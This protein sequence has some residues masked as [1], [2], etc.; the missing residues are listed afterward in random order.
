VKARRATPLHVA[1]RALF[2]LHQDFP[3]W[4]D[5]TLVFGFFPSGLLY[6]V[7]YCGAASLLFFGLTRYA[8]PDHLDGTGEGT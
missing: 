5:A 1:A 8:W 4:G 3:L 7:I 6:H 2:L